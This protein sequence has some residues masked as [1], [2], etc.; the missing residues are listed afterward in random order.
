MGLILWSTNAL[1]PTEEVRKKHPLIPNNLVR[2][3]RVPLGVV[4]PFPDQESPK[5][6]LTTQRGATMNAAT[7]QPRIRTSR[8]QG[9]GAFVE[10]EALPLQPHADN[11]LS[12]I[13]N[14]TFEHSA[15]LSHLPY[16]LISKDNPGC[17]TYIFFCPT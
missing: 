10:S 11:E 3:D 5:E 16:Y 12:N 6:L 8:R 1:N 14:I 17:S 2:R 9:R 15:L 13:S 4:T 7:V